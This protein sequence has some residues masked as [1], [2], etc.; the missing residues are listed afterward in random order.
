[1]LNFASESDNPFQTMRRLLLIIT[2]LF[3]ALGAS[4][5][6][7]KQVF[8]NM[9]DTI[10]PLLTRVNREDFGDFLDSGMA[11]VVKNRFGE[12]AQ[13][14]TLTK[15]YLF[16]KETSASTVEMRL[17]PMSDSIKAICEV[18]TFNA[19]LPDSRVRFY[20]SRWERLDEKDFM[21]EAFFNLRRKG[22]VELSLSQASDSLK[23]V[24][25]IFQG[26]RNEEDSLGVGTVTKQEVVTQ[27]EE[28]MFVWAGGKYVMEH[29][30]ER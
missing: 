18:R 25:R 21:D 7:M 30:S 11:A 3:A 13:M 12:S 14:T 2:V 23:A 19:P 20:S 6:D 1:M 9:P 28:T 15:D 8:I 16:I 26:F 17:L 24:T 27:S 29:I 22:L 10:M 5:Q 4:A